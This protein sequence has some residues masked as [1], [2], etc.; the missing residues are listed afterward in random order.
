MKNPQIEWQQMGRLLCKAEL[1]DISLAEQALLDA[2]LARSPR[3]HDLQRK[4]AQLLREFAAEE[5]ID[6]EK[7]WMRFN[8]TYLNR[9]PRVIP[10]RIAGYAAAV[11]LAMV[12]GWFLV[13]RY[14]VQP[15]IAIN[16]P[17]SNVR[18]LLDDGREFQ[19]GAGNEKITIDGNVE[20]LAG[21]ESM[22]CGI[23]ATPP[24]EAEVH[25]YTVVVPRY[26]FYRMTL[27][28]GTS[29]ILNSKSNLRY[30]IPFREGRREVWLTGE[31]YFEVARD[32]AAPFTVHFPQGEVRVL[33]T[34]FNVNAYE[35][36]RAVSATLLEGSVEC[37]T[38]TAAQRL[39]P[40]NQALFDPLSGGITVRP[41]DIR[42][43][44][45]WTHG[46]FYF[47]NQT[48]GEITDELSRWYDAE[49]V[50]ADESLREEVFTVEI[51]RYETL[52]RVLDMM[53]KTDRI[54]YKQ[55]GRRI[56]LS[57]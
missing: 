40:G 42:V 14:S 28:D 57:E 5:A 37:A 33:G 47:K 10:G 44:T 18:L 39:T 38:A 56:T 29:V 27:P 26:G 4:V 17:E 45:A 15:Q 54:R 43:A 46:N 50:Y 52:N 11:A 41:A 13:S 25:Y 51:G 21:D 48:L 7:A 9:K 36:D 2:W 3:H 35:R 55:D 34:S 32:E 8:R 23:S 6:A 49:V 19:L 1:G 12:G 16:A 24:A 30:P 31:A 53:A 22:S 20:I